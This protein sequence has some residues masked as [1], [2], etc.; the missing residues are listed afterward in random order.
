MNLNQLLALVR[1]R[2]QL[3]LNQIRK[4]GI[5][6]S[7]LLTIFGV[8]LVL[9]VVS[10]FV[11]TLTI[12]VAWLTDASASR[13]MFAWNALVVG[14]LFMWGVNVM[15]R[16]QQ[17]DAISIDKLLHLPITFH[18]AFLLNYVSAFANLTLLS[19]AP[20]MFGLAIATPLARGWPSAIAIPLT[21]SFLFMVTA[22]TYQVRNWLAEKMEN[23]RTKGILLTVLPL[24]FVAIYLSLV[25]FT[26]NRS[27]TNVLSEVGF[28]WLPTGI[29]DAEQGDWFSGVRG[30]LAMTAIGCASLFF[31]YKSSMRK[32]TGTTSRTSK[33]KAPGSATSVNWLGSRMFTSFPGVP[34]SASAVA[35]A[36]MQSLRRAPEVFAALVPSIA[37]AIFGTPYLIGMKGYVVPG[38]TIELLPLA[39]ISVALLGFPAFLFSTFSYDR[40]GFRAFML[41]PVPR[42]DILLGKNLAIGIPTVILGWITMIIL[43]CFIPVGPLWFVGSLICL[44]A[45][46]LLLCIP[47]NAVSVFFSLGLKRGSMT[48]VNTKII[49]VLMLYLGILIGPFVALIPFMVV[50]IAVGLLEKSSTWPL[51][52]LYVLLSLAMLLVSWLVYRRSL[53]EFGEWLWKKESSILDVVANIPE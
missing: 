29:V 26:Q 36:T 15:S 16:V 40:D 34:H 33:K 1:I 11:G 39:M 38:W 44:P 6:N 13:V 48:P 18:S 31:A 51:G 23:K 30:I 50:N 45:S 8:A 52:W 41:S 25:E 9:F 24:L 2:F 14:F 7:I 19:F 5:A 37:L 49:P 47:G 21:L 32:F 46:F 28:G 43:Q 27:F 10:S 3:T 35:M 4:A 42:K 22:I 12:G 20:L 53:V 17:N